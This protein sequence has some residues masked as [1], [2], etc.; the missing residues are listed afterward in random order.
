MAH[1]RKVIRF[2]GTGTSTRAPAGR[3]TGGSCPGTRPAGD[4]RRVS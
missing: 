2:D 1:A 4:P 3:S